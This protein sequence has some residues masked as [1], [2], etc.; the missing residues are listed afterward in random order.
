MFSNLINGTIWK[1][2]INCR[3]KYYRGN[4][5]PYVTV[6]W[7]SFLLYAPDIY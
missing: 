7:G 1:M 5:F 2:G 3:T 4:R 6:D